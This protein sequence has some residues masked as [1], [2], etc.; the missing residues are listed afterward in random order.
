[1]ARMVLPSPSPM[2]DLIK[3]LTETYGPSGFED[4]IRALIR[5][6]VAPLVDEI[7]VDALGNLIA[8]KKG[9]GTGCKVMIAAHMDE[10]GVMVSHITEK[11]FLRFTNIGGV[12]NA[13]LNGKRVQFADGTIGVIGGERRPDRSKVGGL[14]KHYIDVGAVSRA[15]VTQQVGDAAGFWNL[16]IERGSLLTAKSMDDRVCCAIVIETL[17]QLENSPHDLYFAFTVQ[18][19]I[20]VRGAMVVANRVQPD[21][22]IALDVTLSG[23][24]PNA[25]PIAVELGKGPAIKVK[26]SGM[27]AHTGLVKVMKAAAVSAEIPYQLEVLV[28]GST[29]ARAM[30]ISGIG[31]AAGCISVP[32]RYVHSTSETVALSDVEQSVTLLHHILSN[33]INL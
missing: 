4:Q 27:I 9:D 32:C 17:R 8:F 26:D 6:E 20:G 15:D 5:A 28:R 33:P 2:K 29:D 11:G 10:I 22:G 18:E 31:V 30:Q 25:V 23:D 12:S 21:V 14:D 24:T 19:E 16:C 13:D 1:M 7:T 3:K